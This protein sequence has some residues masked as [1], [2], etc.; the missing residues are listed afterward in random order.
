MRLPTVKETFFLGLSKA[1]LNLE[2]ENTDLALLL[3]LVQ[4]KN[5]QNHRQKC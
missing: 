4:T 2:K 3:P 1:S 5:I